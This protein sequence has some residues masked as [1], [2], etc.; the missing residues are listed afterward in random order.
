M[1]AGGVRDTDISDAGMAR[2]AGANFV[3][4]LA[5][6]IPAPGRPSLVERVYKFPGK[7]QISVF[8]SA[9]LPTAGQC[10]PQLQPAVAH[11]H[12]ALA[13]APPP[14]ASCVPRRGAGRTRSVVSCVADHRHRANCPITRR[15]TG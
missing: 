6:A 14:C 3:P 13:P 15:W 1:P 4:R 10:R 5:L 7:E 12:G 9:P 2:E 11:R 8:Q